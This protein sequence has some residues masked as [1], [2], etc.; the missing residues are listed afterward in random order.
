MKVKAICDN[1]KNPIITNKYFRLKNDFKEH[2]CSRDC[3]ERNIIEN[4][5]IRQDIFEEEDEDD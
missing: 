2:F 1:C 3:I 5:E 4:S